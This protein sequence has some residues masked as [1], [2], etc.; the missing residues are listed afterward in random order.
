MIKSL[1]GEEFDIV[2]EKEKSKEILQKIN[3][4]KDVKKAIK[5]KKID[6]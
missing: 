1:W 6:I 5:S 4:Q 3:D 2:S